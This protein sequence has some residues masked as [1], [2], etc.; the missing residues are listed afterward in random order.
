MYRVV[1]DG[2][3]RGIAAMDLNNGSTS[4][5]YL[6]GLN[7][8][9]LDDGWISY[10]AGRVY[11]TGYSEGLFGAIASNLCLFRVSGWV[12]VRFKQ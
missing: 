1:V 3:R 9:Y 10:N 6:S 2:S 11:L 5:Y 8:L 12:E 4:S 7:Y